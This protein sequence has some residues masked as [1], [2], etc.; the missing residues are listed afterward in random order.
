MKIFVTAIGLIWD[1]NR[2]LLE[3]YSRDLFVVRFDKKHGLDVEGATAIECGI[4]DAGLGLVSSS[5]YDSP[6]YRRLLSKRKELEMLLDDEDEVLVLGDTSVESLYILKVLQQSITKSIHLHLWTVTPF[7]FESGNIIEKYKYLLKD[8]NSINSVTITDPLKLIAG[9]NNDS[10]SL[11]K[12][13]D[14]VCQALKES[15]DKHIKTISSLNHEEKYFFDYHNEKFISVDEDIFSWSDNNGVVS[16]RTM[17]ILA[18]NEMIT[19]DVDYD[20]MV[21]RIKQPVPRIDGKEICNRLKELRKAYAE[22]NNIPYSP[23]TCSYEGPCAGTCEHCDDELD[24]LSQKRNGTKV[25]PQFDIS[26]DKL[27]NKGIDE[28]VCEVTMGFLM[29]KEEWEKRNG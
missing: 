4:P 24:T 29:S 23:K 17:G 8:L 26:C 15:F 10:M 7:M 19:N 6:Y 22:A 11:G 5:G 21:R 9:E 12:C 28:T 3:P 18:P 2:A 13:T 16:L 14:M 1:L 25:F 20:E 27:L